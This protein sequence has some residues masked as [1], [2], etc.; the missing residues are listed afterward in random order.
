M[1]SKAVAS[2]STASSSS[3][4][5]CISASGGTGQSSSSTTAST[6][7]KGAFKK[8]L[9]NPV[10][11][12]S[13]SRLNDKSGSQ[14]V[15]PSTSSTTSSSPATLISPSASSLNPSSGPSH[16][17]P[18]GPSTQSNLV[19]QFQDL[20]LKVSPKTQVSSTTTQKVTI[21]ALILYLYNLQYFYFM[22]DYILRGLYTNFNPLS[23]F[24]LL[25]H[26][27]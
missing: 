26:H 1:A 18:S 14:S 17:S 23:L 12:L 16:L 3:T 15:T 7:R 8:W 6:K 19:N 11:K 2:N 25:N 10:R 27:V 21:I 4:T 24:F 22:I 20:S 5:A 13:Q 9:T